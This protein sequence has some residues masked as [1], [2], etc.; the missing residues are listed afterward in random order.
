MTLDRFN[1]IVDNQ[2]N[3]CA[4]VLAEKG[5]EYVFSADRLDHFKNSAEEQGISPKQALWGMTSK[6][7]TSLGRMCKAENGNYSPEVWS[8][9]ITDSMNYMLLLLALVTEEVEANA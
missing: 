4:K 3:H 9:K 7:L 8:E 5:K 6:H 1:E 2:M